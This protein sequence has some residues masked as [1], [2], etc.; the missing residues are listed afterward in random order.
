MTISFNPRVVST[1]V[2]S[3]TTS[4]TNIRRWATVRLILGILQ[5]FGA[6]FS[7]GLIVESGVTPLTLTAVLG[8]GVVTGVSMFLFQVQKR[9][10][11]P[12]A[13]SN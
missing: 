12:T 11:S 6:V 13:K 2:N 8:T 10:Q 5:M 3:E 4:A 9:G 7:L 1:T